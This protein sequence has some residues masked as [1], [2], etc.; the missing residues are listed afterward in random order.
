MFIFLCK[1]KFN[2]LPEVCKCLLT[3]NADNNVTYN[4]RNVYNF[5]IPSHRV[6]LREKCLKV[7]GSKYWNS[8]PDDLKSVDLIIVFKYRLRQLIIEKY[9]LACYMFL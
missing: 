3:L 5:S 8:I 7:R 4:F 2:L 1:Y 6:S 9:Q